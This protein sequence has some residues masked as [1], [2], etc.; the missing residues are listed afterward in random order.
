MPHDVIG[1]L[2]MGGLAARL[3]PLPLSKELYPVGGGPGIPAPVCLHLIEAL[4]RGGVER[5]Y[6]VLRPGKWDIPAYLG[7]GTTLGLRLAYL[8]LGLPFGP[9]Y[10]LDQAYPFVRGARVAM[11]FPDILFEPIDV[12][13]PLITHQATRAA[14]VVLGLFPTHRPDKSDLVDSDADG[15][16]RNILI[17]PGPGRLS[18]TW[19]VAV[20]GPA[21]TEFLHSYLA[22]QVRLANGTPAEMQMSEPILAALRA[23]LRVESLCFPTGR[24]IDIGTPDD[25]RRALRDGLAGT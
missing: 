21:F 6:V 8:T 1:L 7:D 3:G 16:V 12:F 19:I 4:R 14:D 17:K 24:F 15:H 10:T 13:G 11:G 22:E 2:P 20:W 23:G 5:A 18:D 9:P 25:L